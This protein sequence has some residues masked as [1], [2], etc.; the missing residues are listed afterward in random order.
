MGLQFHSMRVAGWKGRAGTSE[1]LP[2][3]FST[4]IL[5]AWGNTTQATLKQIISLSFCYEALAQC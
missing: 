1:V 5:E 2:A 4:I 3:R